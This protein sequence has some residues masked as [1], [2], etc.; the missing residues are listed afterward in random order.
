MRKGFARRRIVPVALAVAIHALFAVA[1]LTRPPE[2]P[3]QD[4]VIQVILAP[5]WPTA[6]KTK[7]AEPAPR[8]ARNDA[9]VGRS[10][11]PSTAR[12]PSG[13][14]AAPG[15]DWTVHA[16]ESEESEGVRSSLRAGT[17]C[18]HADF[19][20]LTKA[21]RQ[22]CDDKL[23]HGAKEAKAYAVISPKLKKEFDG[24]FEC[25]KD[26]VWCEYRIG[27]APYPGL[28]G[29]GKKKRSEWD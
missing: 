28:F 25:P 26:D 22:S 4:V 14:Q 6:A 24:V 11:P 10:S 7:P 20:A 8:T 23:A 21:E 17:G 2:P 27:K 13:R 29:G 18:R 12:S 19:L 1:L 15:R 5:P 16:S 3:L 9:S